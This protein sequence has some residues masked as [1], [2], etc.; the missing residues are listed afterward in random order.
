MAVAGVSTVL[1]GFGAQSLVKD[2]ISGIFIL[3]EDQ[4][5][6]GDFVTIEGK[7]GTVESLGIRITTLRDFDG[8]VHII[9]NGEIKII[10]N[11]S[12]EFKRALVDVYVGYNE[13]VDEVFNILR[14]EMEMAA[15]NIEAII[16]TPKILG[17]TGFE[18]NC[19][20]IRV[21]ANCVVGENWAVERE[22]RRLIKIRFD[23]EGIKFPYPSVVVR[24]SGN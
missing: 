13:N 3:L 18:E 1:I 15:K 12:K 20:K 22:L 11:M 8:N 10:T 5:S 4:F 6:I 17:I 9:P 21:L 14:E 7:T 23:K 19:I 16:E 2:I 24:E